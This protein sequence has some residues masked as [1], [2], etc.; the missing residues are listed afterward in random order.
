MVFAYPARPEAQHTVAVTAS[1]VAWEGAGAS[2]GGELRDGLSSRAC[3][4][5]GLN[6]AST[7]WAS[8]MV[9]ITGAVPLPPTVTGSSLRGL[10]GTRHLVVRTSFAYWLRS[11]ETVDAGTQLWLCGFA[12]QLLSPACLPL[13]SVRHLT[14]GEP[15]SPAAVVLRL[16]PTARPLLAA[17]CPTARLL[18]D[19]TDAYALAVAT[20][21]TVLAEDLADTSVPTDETLATLVTNA[22]RLV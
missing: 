13:V 8:G 14:L 22:K 19:V 17:V 21:A 10:P 1:A 7:V 18:G 4:R 16:D 11:F 2:G 5:V 6:A 3:Q 15:A 12:G 20:F 9:P